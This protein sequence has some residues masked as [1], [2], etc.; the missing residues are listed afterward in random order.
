[1]LDAIQSRSA[2]IEKKNHVIKKYGLKKGL[3][4]IDFLALFPNIHETIEPFTFMETTSMPTD[5]SLLRQLAKRFNSCS[6]FEIGTWQGQSAANL[7]P[8]VNE[9]YTLN[10]SEEEMK[11]KNFSQKYIDNVG[12]LLGNFKNITRIGQSS[13]T[14]DFAALKKKF[15]LIFVDGSHDYEDVKSDT[16]N[17]FGLLRDEQSVIV[18]HDYGI[19]P[20]EIRWEVFAGILDGLPKKEHKNLFHV[21]NTLCAVYMQNNLFKTSH[22]SPPQKPNQLFQVTIS[23]SFSPSP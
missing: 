14:F 22:L 7:A 2:N 20:Q 4:V 19:T 6:Y 17:V 5:Y 16:Q 15:D 10:L 11:E 12:I 13:L 3:P 21:S 9:C 23:S 1:M 18:W 8:L